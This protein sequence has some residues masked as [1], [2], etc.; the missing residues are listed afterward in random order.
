MN[1]K[2]ILTGLLLFFL[3]L[4]CKDVSGQHFSFRQAFGKHNTVRIMLN[5]GKKLSH[6]NF[7]LPQ[8]EKY[9]YIEYPELPKL[10]TRP[11]QLLPGYSVWGTGSDFLDSV[12][13]KEMLERTLRIRNELAP[14][15]EKIFMGATHVIHRGLDI[16]SHKGTTK[17]EIPQQTREQFF[18][19]FAEYLKILK[20]YGIKEV[21]FHLADER[22]GKELEAWLPV[23]DIVHKAGGKIITCMQIG[24]QCFE[25]VGGITDIFLCENGINRNEVDK[26][27]SKGTKIWPIWNPTGGRED[28]DLARR[29]HGLLL[30]KT[31]C[32]G[33]M[34]V[35]YSLDSGWMEAACGKTGLGGDGQQ[36]LVYR[37]A[38]GIIDTIQWEGYREGIDD[39]R[40]IATL[41]KLIEKAKKTGRKKNEV[42]ATKRYLESKVLMWNMET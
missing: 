18:R 19:Y 12:F 38:T 7:H 3:P 15:T 6:I 4:T 39:L 34:E 13:N 23:F 26:W 32:D 35:W 17:I 42:I 11:E 5:N 33:V 31:G 10:P 1:E 28:S 30:W 14:D 41:E 40:Y 25:I 24:A 37:T 27:H 20:K 2:I 9:L 36:N 29:H 8:R 21:Y 16:F 22:D